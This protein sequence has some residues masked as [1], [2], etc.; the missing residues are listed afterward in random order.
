MSHIFVTVVADG[1]D[2]PDN[3]VTSDKS[4]PQMLLTK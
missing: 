2:T 3:F 1:L 4:G